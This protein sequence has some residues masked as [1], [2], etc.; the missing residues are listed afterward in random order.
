MLRSLAAADAVRRLSTRQH[1]AFAR[2]DL[3]DWIGTFVVEGVLELPGNGPLEGHAALSRF[4]GEAGTGAGSPEVLS[5]D[6]VVEVDGVHGTQTSRLLVLDSAGS[7]PAVRGVFETHDDV[8]YERGRW[9]FARR[10]VAR[11]LPAPGT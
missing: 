10:R 8:V 5:T 11:R 1:E 7:P 3:A 2:G 9:Y 4:F 6:S